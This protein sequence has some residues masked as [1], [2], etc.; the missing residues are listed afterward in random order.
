MD[1]LREYFNCRIE[2]RLNMSPMRAKVT[3]FI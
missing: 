3:I 1:T 2:D